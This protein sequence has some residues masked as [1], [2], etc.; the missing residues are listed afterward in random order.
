M[1][2]ANEYLT[3]I[4]LQR[5]RIERLEQLLALNHL[6]IPPRDDTSPTLGASHLDFPA[7][8]FSEPARKP[9][10][11]VEVMSA[12]EG[13]PHIAASISKLWGKD[14][15]DEYLGKLI[16][17][18]RG[19]RKGFSMDAMEE[20]LFLARV[21]RQRKA[22]FGMGFDRT[23]ADVWHEVKDLDRRATKPSP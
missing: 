5:S 2:E 12:L 19:T 8:D 3:I 4:E 22:L 11:S 18:E 21:A 10:E 17:D 9:P 6:P 23:P 20:L 13:F 14:G 1:A 15:F 7:L 16:V